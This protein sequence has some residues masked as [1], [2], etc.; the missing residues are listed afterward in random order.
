[1][2]H[3][4]HLLTLLR[5]ERAPDERRLRARLREVHRSMLREPPLTHPTKVRG[6]HS[7]RYSQDTHERGDDDENAD[8]EQHK[9]TV[10]ICGTGETIV[11]VLPVPVCAVMHT[12]TRIAD[13]SS[14]RR[15]LRRG[16]RCVLWAGGARI[17]LRADASSRRS[18]CALWN[19]AVRHGDV[20]FHHATRTPESHVRRAAVLE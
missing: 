4:C 5:L 15:A 12:V 13:C 6:I 10:G 8:G 1:M 17:W 16:A 11:A 3:E 2:E 19:S 9:C 18:G 20:T 7:P 14:A